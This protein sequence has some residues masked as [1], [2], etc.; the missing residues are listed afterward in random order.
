MKF[1]SWKTNVFAALI[2]FIVFFFLSWRVNLLTTSLMRAGLFSLIIFVTAFLF[3]WMLRKIQAAPIEDDDH[4]EAQGDS[5][6]QKG[7]ESE[8]KQ[9]NEDSLSE[10][11]IELA[12]RFM[13]EKLNE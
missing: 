10:E 8:E 1:D 2:G 6:E 5:V 3:R 11:E 4:I 7:R 13:K 9:E 12:S